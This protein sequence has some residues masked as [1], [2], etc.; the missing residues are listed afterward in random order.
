MLIRLLPWLQRLTFVFGAGELLAAVAVAEL[1]LA[2]GGLTTMGFAAVLTVARGVATRASPEIATAL[3]A[4]ALNAAA[5]IGAVTV[6]G[7]EAPM[8]LLPVLSFAIGL[9]YLRGRSAMAAIVLTAIASIV[10]LVAGELAQPIPMREPIQDIYGKLIVV[11]IVGLVMAGLLDFSTSAVTSLS[12]LR[13][14]IEVQRTMRADRADVGRILALLERLGADAKP[15][16]TA[17]EISRALVTLPG[18]TVAAVLERNKS[19]LRVLGISAPPALPLRAGDQVS[20]VRAQRLIAASSGGPWAE[21]VAAIAPEQRRG[22]QALELRALA[23]A[24]MRWGDDVFGIIEIGTND[25]TTAAHLLE[26]LPAVGEVAAAAGALLGPAVS[27]RRALADA[28]RAIRD[29]IADR[30]F[31]PVFQPIVSIPGREIV[32]YEAL[33]RFMD[34]APPDQH[35]RESAR[36]GLQRELELATLERAI[37]TANTFGPAQPWLS[38][39]V[40]ALLLDEPSQLGHLLRTSRHSIVL[41]LTEHEPVADY[42]QLRQQFLGLGVPFRVAV[43]D[44]GAG[45]ASMKHVVELQ[46][47]LVKLDISLV[48]GIDQDPARQAMVAGM[49]FFADRAKCQLI[50][51]GVETEAELSTLA[52]LGVEYAQ[53]YLVGRPSPFPGQP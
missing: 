27:D 37:E 28:R 23:Y 25:T 12:S 5:L 19:G 14:A 21:S 44:A 42:E 20:D 24:P 52:T 18:I 46:P 48:R 6:A 17:D 47:S 3:I 33:S 38:L 30:A 29:V 7:I 2:I 26:D 31:T 45:Y 40:S 39:N 49:R 22:F 8:A 41:E 11:A 15:E 36:V 10:V 51:E 4:A 53:G 50:A 16:E 43:D 32:G 9:P 13:A 35:F 34:T 1:P